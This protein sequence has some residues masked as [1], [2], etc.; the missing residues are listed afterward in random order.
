M[1]T[2]DK[3]YA[4]KGIGGKVV[5]SESELKELK[6]EEVL[7]RITHASLCYSDVHFLDSGFVLGHEQVGR[8]ERV[9]SA[10]EG[11]QVGDVAGYG[12][13]HKACLVCRECLSGADTLCSS[14]LKR[15][16]GSAEEGHHGGF[17]KYVTMDYRFAHKIPEGMDFSSAAIFMCCGATTFGP[18]FKYGIQPYHRVA[19]SG[20]GGLGHVALQVAR[21]WGCHVTALSS[22]DKK[23][24]DALRFGA[25]E[26]INTSN[27]G[28]SEGLKPFD[29]VI[30]SNNAQP[31]YDG[32]VNVL[33]PRGS[34]ILLAI[35]GSLVATR[36]EHALMLEFFARHKITPQI[37][38]T[39]PLTEKNLQSAFDRLR[40][41]EC[42]YRFV[43]TH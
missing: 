7:I 43:L 16:H 10:T 13:N 33:A 6:P 22:S 24:E 34:L 11:F 4:Y 38:E 28:W 27:E 3:F 17:G 20:I 12:C 25:H 29:F 30:S 32:F 39:M 40:K 2:G 18:F 1:S 35:G 42:K 15:M 31:Q 14:K 23:R 19:I 26:Y 8:V 36:Q 5:K 41:G 37:A 9:G 21:A